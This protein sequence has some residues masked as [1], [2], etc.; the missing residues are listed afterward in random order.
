MTSDPDYYAIIKKVRGRETIH[1]QAIMSAIGELSNLVE[2][3]M[4]DP[5]DEKK[6]KELRENLGDLLITQI[7]YALQLCVIGN[8][9]DFAYAYNMAKEVFQKK[10]KTSNSTFQQLFENLKT[11]LKNFEEKNKGIKK[12]EYYELEQLNSKLDAISNEEIY[13]EFMKRKKAIGE[14]FGKLDFTCF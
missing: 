1:W 3:A 4:E 7:R 5:N 12:S 13:H 6:R 9:N 10:S 11:L 2:D 8:K 14:V